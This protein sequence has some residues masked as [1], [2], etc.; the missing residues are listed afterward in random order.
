M[1]PK[2]STPPPIP[3]REGAGLGRYLKEAF[4]FRWNLLLFLAGSAAALLSPWPD[5]MLPLVAAS[6]LAYLGGLVSIPRFRAAIDA[7][8]HSENQPEPTSEKGR[9]QPTRSVA[10]LVAGL[11]AEARRRFETLHRR[12][13]E[14]RSLAHGVRGTAATRGAGDDMRTPALDRLLWVF[15]RLLV[16]QTALNRFLETT[17]EEKMVRQ[18][19]ELKKNLAAARSEKADKEETDERIARSLQDSVAVAE[20]RLDNYRRAEKNA[21]FVAVELDRIEGKIQVLTEMSVSR[22]DPD[23]LS[24]Q[25]DS[26]TQSMRQTEKAIHELQHI[27]GLTD[28]LEEPPAILESNLKE[29]LESEA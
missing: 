2:R 22:Q 27:T 6:E 24:R 14:M 9:S 10:E 26:V 28:E 15:L 16:S 11:P 8:A 21:E 29:V 13:L 7:K 18:I 25:V 3:V 19:D 1:A 12:C 4:F 20:L 17:D 23:F 5:V